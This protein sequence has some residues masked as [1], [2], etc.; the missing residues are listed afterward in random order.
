MLHG[1]DI[2]LNLL[3]YVVFLEVISS[4]FIWA[5]SLTNQQF[6]KPCAHFLYASN[7]RDKQ[8]QGVDAYIWSSLMRPCQRPKQLDNTDLLYKPVCAAI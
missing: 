7:N 3:T 4:F 2:F 1:V 8:K 6:R 5:R